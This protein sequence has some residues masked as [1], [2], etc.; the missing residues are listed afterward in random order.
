[1]NFSLI[2]FVG[3]RNWLISEQVWGVGRSTLYMLPV[4]IS[5]DKFPFSGKNQNISMEQMFW[6]NQA[7]IKSLLCK[8]CLGVEGDLGEFGF[9]EIP[10]Q[11]W[12][13]NFYYLSVRKSYA[14]NCIGKWLKLENN[15][16]RKRYPTLRKSSATFFFCSF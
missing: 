6:S 4:D 7:N 2:G 1:M 8:L 16:L 10:K 13:I 9:W 15:V 5:L 12:W 11:G 3:S 14:A